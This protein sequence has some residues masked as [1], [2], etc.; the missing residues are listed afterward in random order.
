[1]SEAGGGGGV[2]GLEEGVGMLVWHWE[3]TWAWRSRCA[4]ARS[5]WVS[6]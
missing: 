6:G 1:M 3:A 5:A 4:C 2:R